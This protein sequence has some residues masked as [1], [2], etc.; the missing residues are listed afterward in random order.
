[1]TRTISDD[2]VEQIVI[3]TL[4]TT[5]ND[6]THRP[7]EVGLAALTTKKLQRSTHESVNALAADIVEWV[8]HWNENPLRSSGTK[9][10]TKSSNDSAAT[11]PPSPKT[12]S[13]T[14]QPDRTPGGQRRS[15]RE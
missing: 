9:P 10:P 12:I 2:V 5:P 1:M 4:E 11:A 14:E 3:D 15:A 8:D 6:A 13:L 7:S